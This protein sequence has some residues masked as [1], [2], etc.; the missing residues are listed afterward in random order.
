MY[1]LNLPLR[2]N[3]GGMGHWP[4]GYKGGHI[5]GIYPGYD[6]DENWGYGHW[7]QGPWGQG[8]MGSGYGPVSAP[9]VYP[10]ANLGAYPFSP[11]IGQITIPVL[12]GTAVPVPYTY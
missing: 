4:G 9:I 8:N 10:V 6:Y 11:Y 7:S 3:Y 5:H 2:V 1:N 12:S